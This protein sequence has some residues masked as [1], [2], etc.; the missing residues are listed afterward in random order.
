MSN[1]FFHIAVLAYL[2]AT[3]VYIG[4]LVSRKEPVVKAAQWILV[5]GFAFHTF[6]ILSR[7]FMAARTPVTNLHESLTF[8]SWI[9]VALY[10]VLLV[11]YKQRVLGAFVAPFAFILIISA[12]FFPEE[13]VPLAPTLISYWLPVHV[14]LAFLGNAFFALAFFLGIMY[15]IQERY[16]KRRKL[17]GL[18]YILPSL[19]LL[20]GL[21]YR[22]I[23][24]GFPL[25]TLAMITGAMWSEYTLGSYWVWKPRQI[26]SLITWFLYAAL[27]HGRLTSGWRGRKAALLSGTAFLVL[28]GSFFAINFFLGGAHGIK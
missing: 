15:I 7:W 26:W 21:N 20:D 18:Y 10:M 1:I 11:R 9:T 28:I 8:F 25:L 6:T 3:F 4:Y 13:I 16:L 17:K 27:L 22:C 2:V 24:Y 14:I 12:S 19:D 5:G 23:Q